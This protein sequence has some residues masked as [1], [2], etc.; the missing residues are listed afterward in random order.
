[1]KQG[2]CPLCDYIAIITTHRSDQLSD[3]K[4]SVTEIK[5][6]EESDHCGSGN[7]PDTVD[8]NNQPS[9]STQTRVY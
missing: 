9:D 2:I 7:D 6:Y 5:K 4:D 1:M 8:D 3:T